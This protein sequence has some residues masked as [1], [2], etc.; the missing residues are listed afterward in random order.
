MPYIVYK[1]RFAQCVLGFA[2]CMGVLFQRIK[3]SANAFISF[4]NYIAY[5]VHSAK[6]TENQDN[7]E[8]AFSHIAEK[9]KQTST[10]NIFGKGVLICDIITD[11]ANV[12]RVAVILLVPPVRLL[13]RPS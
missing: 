1:S 13:Y 8:N 3:T 4:I 11:D 9:L 10:F 7:H 12:K 5:D 2:V 6:F